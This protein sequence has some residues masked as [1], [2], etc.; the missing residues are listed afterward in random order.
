[1][2]P[3]VAVNVA[4]RLEVRRRGRE[5][6]VREQAGCLCR[7]ASQAP[8][9]SWSLILIMAGGLWWVLK[10]DRDLTASPVERL[11]PVLGGLRGGVGAARWWE[12]AAVVM[13]TR[14][15]V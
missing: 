4:A 2:N 1:M 11:V 13:G 14:G 3:E 6:L 8:G 5:K 15:W 9:R 7:G 12:E 10:E